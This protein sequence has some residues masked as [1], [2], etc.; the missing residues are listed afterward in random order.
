MFNL[1]TDEILRAYTCCHGP[2]NL[3]GEALHEWEMRMIDLLGPAN[4][5]FI[6]RC[7][8]GYSK[9]MFLM[10]GHGDG[11]FFHPKA[12][13]AAHMNWCEAALRCT[14]NRTLEAIRIISKNEALTSKG[15]I[16]SLLT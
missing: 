10:K 12:K 11:W 1:K 8:S 6:I 2:D 16:I 7:R 14:N 9:G 3:R 5:D 13:E 15:E 4:C